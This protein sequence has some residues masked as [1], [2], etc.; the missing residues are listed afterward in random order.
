MKGWGS[1]GRSAAF[2]LLVCVTAPFALLGIAVVLAMVALYVAAE[3]IV[4]NATR[5]AALALVA[6]AVVVILVLLGY[7]HVR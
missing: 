3:A 1:V 7:V 6:V 2:L 4:K 5:V